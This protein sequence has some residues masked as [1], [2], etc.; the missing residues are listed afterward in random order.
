[1]RWHGNCARHS[2]FLVLLAIL[3]GAPGVMRQAAAQ[4]ERTG[5]EVVGRSD[6]DEPLEEWFVY[7]AKDKGA[8]RKRVA[9]V[10]KMW[11]FTKLP[12]GNFVVALVPHNSS[13]LEI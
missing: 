13:A 10:R 3:G 7:D 12:P 9:R 5:I 4:D 1:C 6:K 2:S 11:G 8:D